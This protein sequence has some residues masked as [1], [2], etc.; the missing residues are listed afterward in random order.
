MRWMAVLSVAV[1]GL[2]APSAGEAGGPPMR[3]HG[4]RLLTRPAM[5]VR[6]ALAPP[7]PAP[8]KVRKPRFVP[9]IVGTPEDVWIVQSAPPVLAAPEPEREPREPAPRPV[10]EPKILTPPTSSPA[11]RPGEHVVVV[12]RG[13]RIEV[14]AFPVDGKD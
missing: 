6:P 14:Q 8:P 7:A 10:A 3:G 2:S 1:L 9:V 4:D 12:Q 13:D 11:A 5:P